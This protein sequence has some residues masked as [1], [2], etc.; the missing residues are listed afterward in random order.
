MNKKLILLLL[1]LLIF[2]LIIILL[3][4]KKNRKEYYKI[5]SFQFSPL[6]W[7]S[8]YLYNSN[9]AKSLELLS[10][11]SLQL[12]I[13]DD[14]NK[15]HLSYQSPYIH[16]GDLGST[17]NNNIG[18][19]EISNNILNDEQY[20]NLEK[21]TKDN[22]TY[23]R[24]DHLLQ[25]I[26]S[27]EN[28]F[29]HP[30]YG[31]MIERDALDIVID[32]VKDVANDIGDFFQDIPGQVR[33]LVNKMISWVSSNAVIIWNDTLKDKVSGIIKLVLQ[34]SQCEYLINLNI[35]ELEAFQVI[36][37]YLYP[38]LR[39]IVKRFL[40]SSIDA[41]MPEIMPFIEL[42]VDTG[43][44]NEYLDPELDNLIQIILEQF[45]HEI[46]QIISPLINQLSWTCDWTN[47]PNVDDINIKD[48]ST[49]SLGSNTDWL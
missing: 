21:I 49:D 7:I 37:P 34:D 39:P 3:Y 27:L 15:L 11:N 33:K 26:L 1:I 47:L 8:T 5:E 10:P 17:D 23:V 43:L 4:K 6:P 24:I 22:K 42:I 38:E 46:V 36:E 14:T 9:L 32:K 44:L 48:S 19:I 28:L 40:I 45:T 12:N 13:L 30:I 18:L 35:S 16:I 2:I 31:K 29:R 25:F 20:K 41:I